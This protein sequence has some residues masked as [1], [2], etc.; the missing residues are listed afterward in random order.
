[1]IP[2]PTPTRVME[3]TASKECEGRRPARD[4]AVEWPDL[5]EVQPLCSFETE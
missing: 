3:A 1:M 5:A 2:S 4:Q